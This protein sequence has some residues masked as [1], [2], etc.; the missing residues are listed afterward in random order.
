LADVPVLLL[1]TH[2]QMI[3]NAPAYA[4][5]IELNLTPSCP[6]YVIYTSGSTGA[7]KGVVITHK[8]VMNY[9]RDQIKLFNCSPHSRV[10]QFLPIQF[11]AS[12]SEINVALTSGA[13]LCFFDEQTQ[14]NVSRWVQFADF[15]LALVYASFLTL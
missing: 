6:S 14:L 8:G 3:D 4:D 15:F 10:L 5:N 7:P 13:A 2:W 12:L 9:V 11:D 1:D